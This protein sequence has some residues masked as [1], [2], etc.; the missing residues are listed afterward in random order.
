[1]SKSTQVFLWLMAA[2]AGVLAI[3]FGI[4]VWR[5]LDS[6]PDRVLPYKQVDGVVL[7]LDL[8][9]PR[10]E[11]PERGYPALLLF[12]GGGWKHG[13]PWQFHPQCEVFAR[14]GIACFSA[15]YRTASKFSSTPQ[16]AV[17]DALDAW[18]YLEEQ[19]PHLGLDPASLFAGGGSAG[20]HLAAMLGGD[21]VP[22]GRRPVALILYNPLL[23]LA[24][25][26]YAHERFG[27]GWAMLSPHHR[28][29]APAPDALIMSGTEDPE[30]LVPTLR[31]FCSRLEQ[32]GGRCSLELFSGAQH[33]FFNPG[34]GQDEYFH[35]TN[36]LV[37]AYVLGHGS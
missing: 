9:L 21:L 10:G 1:M 25:G 11:R 29:A 2:G 20:G 16:E 13:A 4:V 35:S 12:H 27:A 14:A 22:E 26:Y 17:S 30:V 28:L 3:A 8:F 23:N 19:A 6:N 34:R 24:P 32:F 5:L 18:S 7:S 36:D 31:Q 15:Q 37:I 33:G